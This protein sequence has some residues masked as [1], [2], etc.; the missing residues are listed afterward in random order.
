MRVHVFVRHLFLLLAFVSPAILRA[1]FQ[2]STADE[3]KMTADPKAPGAAAVY[4]NVEE[5]DNDPLHF[6]SFY[7]RIKVLSEKGK[8]LATVELPY[9]KGNTK[10]T[11][12][13][14]R[15]IHADGTIIPLTG[16]P[17]DLLIAKTRSKEG[18]QQQFNRKVFTLPS[19]EVGSILEYRY[20]IEYDDNHFSSPSWEIQR[21][22]LVHKAHYVFTP[23]KAFLPGSQNQ[24]SMYL[25]DEHGHVI[26]TLIWWPRL[27]QGVTVKTDAAGRYS[28][29]ITDVPPIPEEEWMPPVK[30]FLYKV[31]FYYKS[32]TSA[33][34][35]WVSETKL[36]SKDLDHF[37]EPSKSLHQA[38]DSLIAPGDSDLDKAKK[39]YKAVQALDNTD[40][41]RKKSD[42]ELKQLKLRV[43]KHAEDTWTQKSGSSEDIALLYLAMLRAAGLTA[44]AVKV[45]DRE[46]GLFDISYLTL[47]QL[48]D[49]LV[50]LNTGGKDILLDP[51]EKMCPFQTISWRHSEAGGIGQ[52][53]DGRSA[54][55]SPT[56]AYPDNKLI[57]SGNITLDEHGAV[58]GSFNFVMSGQQALRWRQIALTNDLDEVKKQF[59]HELESIVPDGIEAHIDHFLGLDD[60]N[61]NLMAIV[62]VQGSM[63][64]AT[65]KRLMLP[66]FFF[67]TRSGHP[68]V[69][70]DKRQEPVDMHYGDIVTDQ[71]TYH[72]PAGFSV[73][74]APQDNKI[75]WPAHAILS[76][77][78]ASS[79][80]QIIIA[81][82]LARAFTFAKPDE[83][84]DLR[85]FYQKVAAADQAQL[86]LT[87]SP[88][89]KGN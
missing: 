37:A 47:D 85:S 51:G 25:E 35:F 26:N 87:T 79:P 71:V 24:T 13:K 86:V 28:V 19:V 50:V 16:K 22:Y 56:Q 88:A 7:A 38:V 1:Q 33:V 83:Y 57:R 40:Y 61:V 17:E 58:T 72:L 4:L 74:G 84:Q 75:S 42:A 67:E 18:D 77:K 45:V 5:I 60:P 69:A 14:G 39:L 65:S 59:D 80:G 6:Q 89:T 30:S 73:E 29:D 82:S 62:K 66:G 15:T 46:Q 44:Y 34:N 64:A 8:E 21:P 76:Y 11:E 32:D 55:V 12:I 68:F 78:T 31:L 36:W 20:Q 10:I 54:I 3:L 43:A 70:Q 53:S 23:F 81:R 52:S 48:D 49:T 2:Q 41:S 9:L 63:G 27:P